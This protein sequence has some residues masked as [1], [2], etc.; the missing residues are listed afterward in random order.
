MFCGVSVS[1][2]QSEKQGAVRRFYG[3]G[4]R[5]GIIDN[6]D[7]DQCVKMRDRLVAIYVLVC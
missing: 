1:A 6:D 5:G 2:A 3:E 4:A 7:D